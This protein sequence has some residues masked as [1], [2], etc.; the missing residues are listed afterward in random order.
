MDY[1]SSPAIET[2]KKDPVLPRSIWELNT[3]K[4]VHI[5]VDLTDRPPLRFFV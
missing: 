3:V 5:V 2:E 1:F 4:V